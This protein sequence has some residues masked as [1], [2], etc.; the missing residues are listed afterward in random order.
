MVSFVKMLGC[1]F[2]FGRV[3][4]AHLPANKAQAE[5]NPPI[6]QLH[7]FLTDMLFGLSDFDLI[8]VCTFFR[9]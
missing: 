2:V 4:T 1:M 8:K 3:A 5:V 9:H 6:A 7:T